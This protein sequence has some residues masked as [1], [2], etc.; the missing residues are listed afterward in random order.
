VEVALQAAPL[1]VRGRDD[2]RAGVAG[3]DAYLVKPAM[4]EDL[5][6]LLAAWKRP[7]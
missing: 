7:T 3:F 6:R 4:Y 1:R 2:A 5:S